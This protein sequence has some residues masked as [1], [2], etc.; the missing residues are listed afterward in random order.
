MKKIVIAF[1]TLVIIDPYIGIDYDE[2][3]LY[4]IDEEGSHITDY[5]QIIVIEGYENPKSKDRKENLLETIN[6]YWRNVPYQ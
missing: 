6:N 5:R 1:F 3:T 4:L 2:P